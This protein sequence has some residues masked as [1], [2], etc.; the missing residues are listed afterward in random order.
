MLN[1]RRPLHLLTDSSSAHHCALL[2]CSPL[3]SSSCML[4]K[5]RIVQTAYSCSPSCM[6]GTFTTG[7]LSCL[8]QQQPS[9]RQQQGRQN[10]AAAP[11]PGDQASC[12]VKSVPCN[13]QTLKECSQG[14]TAQLL[15]YLAE[16]L[17]CGFTRVLASHDDVEAATLIPADRLS[18]MHQAGRHGCFGVQ[19]AAQAAG[20]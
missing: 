8:K 18:S 4:A 20:Q 3:R 13:S 7:L 9:S 5:G 16:R 11:L 1:T 17:G 15:T 12:T 2:S 19:D 10:C 14:L 6:L